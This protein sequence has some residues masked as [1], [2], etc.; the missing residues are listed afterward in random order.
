MADQIGQILP[1]RG[2]SL[3][4]PDCD[5]DGPAS[6]CR[7]GSGIEAQHQDRYIGGHIC[8]QNPFSGLFAQDLIC[9]TGAAGEGFFHQLLIA[10]LPEPAPGKGII[11][12]SFQ[13]F[14]RQL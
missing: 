13:D 3:I 10:C 1:Q 14:I 8:L 5:F 6:I 7:H 9:Q 2:C 12:E 4:I 11:N